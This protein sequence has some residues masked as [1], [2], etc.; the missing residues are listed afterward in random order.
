MP[1]VGTEVVI[2]ILIVGIF[3]FGAPRVKGWAKAIREAR[4]ELEGKE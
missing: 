3:L 1:V 4:K 2:V